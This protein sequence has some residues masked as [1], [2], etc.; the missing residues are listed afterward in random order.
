M[1]VQEYRLFMQASNGRPIG[2][3][4]VF[5]AATDEAAIRRAMQRSYAE[6]AELWAGERFVTLFRGGD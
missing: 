4:E 1:P 2:E 6:D 5:E 3:P